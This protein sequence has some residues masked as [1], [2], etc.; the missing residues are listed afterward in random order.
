MD[1]TVGVLVTLALAGIIG[2]VVVIAKVMKPSV[3]YGWICATCGSSAEGKSRTPGS[4][5]FE[6]ALWIA[7]LWYVGGRYATQLRLPAEL[8]SL[9]DTQ[10]WLLL[11]PLGYT[12]YRVAARKR[13]CEACGGALLVPADSPVGQR[14]RAENRKSGPPG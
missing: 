7:G 1:G 12:V 2:V 14:I 8:Q 13:R 3:G 11:I 6:L 9:Y 4:F 5:I 10:A